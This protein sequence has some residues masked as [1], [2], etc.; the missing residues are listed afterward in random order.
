M[1]CGCR[2]VHIVIINTAVI[3]VIIIIVRIRGDGISMANVVYDNTFGGCRRWAGAVDAY[4]G[5]PIA[6]GAHWRHE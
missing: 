1:V 6:I 4:I 5:R 3:V 2:S